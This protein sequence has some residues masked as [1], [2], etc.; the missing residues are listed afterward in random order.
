LSKFRA[1]AA[2]FALAVPLAVG[3]PVAHATPNA[4]MK[5]NA[6]AKH[7][8]NRTVV[9]LAQFEPGVSRKQARTIVRAHHGKITNDLAAIH[10]YAVKLPAKQARALKS[11]K[12]SP[13]SR[14]TPRSR[15]PAWATRRACRRPT[16]RASA[17]PG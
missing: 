5:L 14:S 11:A 15:R 1:A 7:S 13:T 10:G 2:L 3:G 17:P 12:A 9:A 16:R 4:A 6:A 8:P